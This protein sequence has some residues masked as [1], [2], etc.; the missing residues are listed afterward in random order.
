VR[1]G[2]AVEKKLRIAN[3][4]AGPSYKKEAFIV[5][6]TLLLVLVL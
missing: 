4:K 1:G 6:L 3:T 5:V 2:G